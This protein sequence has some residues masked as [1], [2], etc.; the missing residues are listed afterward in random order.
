MKARKIIVG[1]I[2]IVIAVY[3][4]IA[5]ESFAAR[6]I[7]GG[8]VAILGLASVLAGLVGKGEVKKEEKKEEAEVKEEE[9]VKEEKV[10]E[11]K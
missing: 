7:G 2:L 10:E 11:K 4:F 9:P 6:F 5:T 8:I 1:L 3:L